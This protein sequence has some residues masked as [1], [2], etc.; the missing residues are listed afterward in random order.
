M[1]YEVHIKQM[2]DVHVATMRTHRRARIGGEMSSTLSRIACAANPPGS[3]HGT[4]FAIRHDAP[5]APE[6]PDVELGLPIALGATVPPDVG[7]VKDLDGGPFACTVHVG[8]Y[9]SIGEAYEA[10]FAWLA[11][12]GL[13]AKGPP[14][15]SY[16]LG[17]TPSVQPD[18]YQTEIAVPVE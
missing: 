12:H 16:I 4:A 9:A 6:E 10:L 14:R 15:E 1:Q 2:P 5:D 18:E 8:S 7:T 3:A 11:S 17:P 13:R